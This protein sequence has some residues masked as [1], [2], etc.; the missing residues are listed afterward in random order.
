MNICYFSSCRLLLLKYRAHINIEIVGSVGAIKYLFKYIHKG[1]DRV[2]VE[3]DLRS[4][5]DVDNDEITQH[6]NAS[7]YVYFTSWLS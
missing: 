5:E 2:M 3:K 6:I 1:P 7:W 4:K